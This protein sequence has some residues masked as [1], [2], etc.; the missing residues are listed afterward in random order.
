MST[1]ATAA[2]RVEKQQVLLLVL[3]LGLAAIVRFFA[4]DASSLWHDE[5]NSW[6]LIQ[7]GYQQIARDAAADIHP[8]GYYWLLKVWS[9]L[10]GTSAMAIRS[11][12][13]I[14][15][16]LLVYVV[17][18]IGRQS[19]KQE[20][21]AEQFLPYFPL[22]AA[23][24]TALNPFQIYYSQ[25]A[26]MY[27]LLAL[28]SALVMWALLAL[29]SLPA[30]QARGGLLSWRRW[31]NWPSAL[32]VGAGVA[33]LWTHYSFPIVLLAASIGYLLTWFLVRGQADGLAQTDDPGDTPQWGNLIHF[34]VLNLVVILLYL[35][36]L[37]TAVTRVL[38]WP[39]GGVATSPMDGLQ[40]SMTTLLFGP[41]QSVVELPWLWTLAALL[42]PI[43]GAIALR[44]TRSWIALSLW[45][46]APIGLMFALGLFSEAFLKFL[47]VAS[48]AWALLAAASPSLVRGRPRLT[49]GLQ[50]TVAV[51]AALVAVQLLP[52]YYAD[53]LVRDNYA[54]VARYVAAVGDPET[55]LVLLNAPGQRDVWSYYDPGLPTLA[56]PTSRPPDPSA[57]F[58]RLADETA[59]KDRIYA[60]F[61]A[62]DESDPENVVE[63]WLGRSAFKGPE[64]WQGN[65][66]FVVYSLPHQLQ[67]RALEEAVIFGD[68]FALDEVCSVPD[69]EQVG[70]G[71]ALPVALRW[72]LQSQTEARYAMSLQL[73]DQQGQV[74]AQRDGE[75][76]GGSRPTST[77][78]ADEVIVDN[79]AI[80]IPVGT[81]PGRYSLA[82][83]L[84]DPASGQRLQ[85]KA[86]E[87]WSLGTVDLRSTAAEM[88]S[89]I[90]PVG[91][92]VD[93]QLGPATL[94]GYDLYR[95]GF[96]HAPHT[97]LRVG[98]TIELVLTWQAPKVLPANWPEDA[99][100]TLE[101][102]EER[103]AQSLGG[104]GYP[105]A[106]WQPGEFVRTI[107]QVPYA[108]EGDSLQLHVMEDTLTL[109]PLP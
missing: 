54:G 92:R 9:T 103:T 10:F 5:G 81:P 76:A 45:L 94:V 64:S 100:F 59:G 44:R 55:D 86:G 91:N 14:C 22:L 80:P 41:M 50:A 68:L 32:F 30:V 85:T 4:I 74:V 3:I 104:S 84:Y 61:W 20:T 2:S 43:L 65:M 108:T 35:P 57:T 15:S 102:G 17:Y 72:R 18:A 63:S 33:G 83:V 107:V 75:P 105:T 40:Q 39:K 8:P 27:A 48:P 90:V 46:L 34:V 47:L 70:G 13:A 21:V 42:L 12:S 77:W 78:S 98:D 97:A 62:T 82:L 31:L 28:E 60:L 96:A 106:E 58:E 25:E 71:E 11:L 29:L 6:A 66:R 87:A 1:N 73:Q 101:F 69:G 93:R 37:P 49:H 95:R 99:Q 88:P 67:C 53:D 24:I 26:R 38:Q 79:H 36:W 109:G 16:L 19:V 89:E 52:A 23:L 51:A 7:R 56:L